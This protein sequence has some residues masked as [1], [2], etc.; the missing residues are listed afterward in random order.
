MARKAQA[1]A[2]SRGIAGRHLLGG[3]IATVL[4]TPAGSVAFFMANM[5]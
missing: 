4:N 1:S 2:L 5:M 3:G